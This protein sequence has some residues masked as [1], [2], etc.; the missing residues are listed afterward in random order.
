MGS[1]AYL[2]LPGKQGVQ[3]P[4]S[5]DVPSSAC[6]CGTSGPFPQP[7]RKG[8]GVGGSGEGDLPFSTGLVQVQPERGR[9]AGCSEQVLTSPLLHQKRAWGHSSGGRSAPASQDAI[10]SCPGAGCA[11]QRDWPWGAR[12]S[13]PSNWDFSSLL[14]PQAGVVGAYWHPQPMPGIPLSPQV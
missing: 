6:G 10:K 11:L 4:D 7:D 9:C 14:L 5:R 13:S 12:S 3:A 2:S 1:S 8:E